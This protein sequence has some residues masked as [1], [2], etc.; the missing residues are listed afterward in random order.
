MLRTLVSRGFYVQ[1]YADDLAVLVKGAG[2]LWIKA[3]DQ[4]AIDIDA[5]WASEQELQFSSKKT[6]IVLLTHKRNPCLGALSIDGSKHELSKEAKLLGASL[7]S[8][9]TLKPHITRIT[10][11]ATTTLMQ[12]RKFAGETWGIQPSMM[13]WIHTALIRPIISYACVSW[14]GSFNKKYLGRKLTK[15]Q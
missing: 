14:A 12:C 7:D 5:N 6:D 9:L 13:K 8:K 15:V 10:L 1:A 2:M 4:K 11:K 3:M